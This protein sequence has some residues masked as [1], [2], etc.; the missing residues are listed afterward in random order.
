MSDACEAKREGVTAA[1][2]EKPEEDSLEQ[3]SGELGALW[4][5]SPEDLVHMSYEMREK[6]GEEESKFQPEWLNRV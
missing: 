4:K 3:N 2:K 1:A 5:Q 6:R